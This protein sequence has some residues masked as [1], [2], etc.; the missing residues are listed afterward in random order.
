MVTTQFF[1]MKI[2]RYL[3]DHDISAGTLA[4]VAAKAFRNGALNPNAWR[5]KPI[6]EEEIESRACS[7]T[8][9]RS[10]C[11]A[12]PTRAPPRSWS[13]GPTRPTTTPTR[14]VHVRGVAVRTRRFGTFEVFAP[15]LSTD[16]T[17]SPTVDASR[18]VYEQAGIGPED[19]Q[20][21][22][23]QDS[24]SGAEI[25]HMAENG[26]CADGE[27]E[28]WIVGRRDR[29]RR[30]PPGQHRWRPAGQRRADRRVRHAPD[31]RDRAAAPRR[32]RPPPGA[33]RPR[34]GYTQVYGA[35]GIGACTVLTR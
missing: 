22:Q 16:T 8:R 32:C 7:T 5:Q 9:S 20:V 30:T 26:F 23:L 17:E 27:Q 21:A 25:M 31:P 28:R 24:E 2:N 15:W 29:D 1:A 10:T 34:V 4:K 3:H 33:G 13:A 19:V 11:S 35:P 18:A 14:P 12:R 6:S